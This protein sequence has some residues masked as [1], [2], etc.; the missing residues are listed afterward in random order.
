MKVVAL[1]TSRLQKKELE[2]L[3]WAHRHLEHPSFAARVSSLVG[4][5][6]EESLKLLPKSWF[7]KL[8]D[9]VEGSIR[10]SLDVAIE[11]IDVVTPKFSSSHFHRFMA[12]GTGAVGGFLG[13]IALLAEL[14]LMTTLILRAIA[15]IALEEGEDLEDTHTRIACVEVFA[16]GARSKADSSAEAGYFGVR[17]M[18]GLHFSTSLV[19]VAEDKAIAIPGGV[20][21]MRAVAARFGMVVED[22]VAAKM[23]PVVGAASGAALNLI[24]M[25]HYLDVARG[26]FIVRRLERKH[27]VETIKNLYER[28]TEEEIANQNYS[29]VEGW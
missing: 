6:I 18:L 29:P 26:H 16:F 19:N 9:A 21:F 11:S 8:H 22:K 27:G 13:P 15:E 25:N 2:Q 7:K 20:E 1:E 5:P 14:P 28:I 23:I 4:S 12:A 24:F 17:S 3:K 10:Q